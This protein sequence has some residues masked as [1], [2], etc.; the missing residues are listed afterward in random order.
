MAGG[1]KLGTINPRVNKLF[2]VYCL[3][4]VKLINMKLNCFT[5]IGN[6]QL[7]L[8]LI[9]TSDRSKISNDQYR[10]RFNVSLNLLS[11]FANT[12]FKS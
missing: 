10:I 3:H 2:I 8:K 6:N 7:N 4:S 9:D 1:G 12:P 5:Q 11:F